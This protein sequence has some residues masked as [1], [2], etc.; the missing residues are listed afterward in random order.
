MDPKAW[1][2]LLFDTGAVAINR[3]HFG[4]LAPKSPLF[5]D[6]INVMIEYLYN[7]TSTKWFIPTYFWSES[8][9]LFRPSDHMTS[10]ART[11]KL[12]RLAR[13]NGRLKDCIDNEYTTFLKV[14]ISMHDD[15]IGH[16]YL[17]VCDIFHKKTEI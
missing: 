10:S 17:L 13:F 4:S 9:K 6:V 3:H 2:E 7:T 5:N 1:S 12:C 15:V 8:A 11:H 14:Y 16:W